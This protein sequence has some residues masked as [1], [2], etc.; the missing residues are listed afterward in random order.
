LLNIWDAYHDSCEKLSQKALR[1]FCKG[2]YL[3]YLRMREWRDL[4]HQLKESLEDLKLY[5]PSSSVVH[6]DDQALKPTSYRYRSIHR[7]LLTGL[8][9]HVATK[10]KGNFYIGPHN[11]HVMLFPGS[12]LFD[13][14]ADKKPAPGE[15]EIQKSRTPQWI[16]CGEWL[17]T[18]NLYAHTVAAIEPDWL[19][20]IADHVIQRSYG[21]PFWDRKKGRVLVRE[22]RFLYGL[23]I[24]SSHI[25]YASIDPEKACEI[26]IQEALVADDIDQPFKF[27]LHN[28]AIKEEAESVVQRLRLMHGGAIDEVLFNFYAKRIHS[29]SSVPELFKH[30][31]SHSHESLS[32]NL[33]DLIHPQ[34]LERANAL[35]PKTLTV[36]GKPYDILYE[37]DG[38]DLQSHGTLILDV[39]GFANLD[40]GSLGWI[41]PGYWHAWLENYLWSLPKPLRVQLSPLQDTI[42]GLHR[43]LWDHHKKATKPFEFFVLDQLKLRLEDLSALQAAPML[44]FPLKIRV[45]DGHGRKIVEGQ[46]YQ[47][48]KPLLKDQI[49]ALRQTLQETPKAQS[50]LKRT[51]MEYAAGPLKDWPSKT[52]PE[53]IPLGDV[54]GIPLQAYG[55]LML[56]QEGVFIHIFETKAEAQQASVAAYRALLFQGIQP[57]WEGFIKDCQNLRKIPPF[58]WP[59]P[60][61]QAL[62]DIEDAVK[63]YALEA[64]VPWPLQAHFFYDRR[65][66]LKKE[67]RSLA[68]EVDQ[69]LRKAFAAYKLIPKGNPLIQAEIDQLFYPGF[70]KEI[71]VSQWKH[72]EVYLKALQIRSQKRIEN[73]QKDQRNFDLIKPWLNHYKSLSAIT[74]PPALKR[75]YEVFRWMIESYKVSVFAQALKAP[76]PVSPQKLQEAWTEIAQ[77]LKR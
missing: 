39:E 42:D 76:I 22:K 7:A 57:E 51:Q 9:T 47:S 1:N 41:I 18:S 62:I 70:L 74:L 33:E 19:L 23:L 4:Y 66:G 37:A 72:L 3:S 43:A 36:K 52:P 60:V 56:A 27:L 29:I 10:N 32:L 54:E 14:K 58:D 68:F 31:Q 20:E 44:R 40:S 8:L 35:Y 34:D 61:S 16:V 25:G 11:R 77:S 21:D 59:M 64:P 48:L 12:A 46:D 73:P 15:P 63:R 67:L 53:S 69:W 26:F 55:G 13:R 45:C 75:K 2:H 71:P 65:D 6:A 49:K 30:L 24:H 50:L 38:E 5:K 17:E 28:R